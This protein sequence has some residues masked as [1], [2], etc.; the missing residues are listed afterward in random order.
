[1]HTKAG[2]HTLLLTNAPTLTSLL[3]RGKRSP[4]AR[5]TSSVP[6]EQYCPVF[7]TFTY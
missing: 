7:S 3:G 4:D 5:A 6:C 1:M 2:Q